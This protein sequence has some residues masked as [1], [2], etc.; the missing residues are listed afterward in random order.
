MTCALSLTAISMTGAAC[1]IVLGV[2]LILHSRLSRASWWSIDAAGNQVFFAF[3]LLGVEA[4]TAF[5][6]LGILT[7]GVV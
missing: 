2:G 4:V 5:A 1:A 6:A 7:N 3:S